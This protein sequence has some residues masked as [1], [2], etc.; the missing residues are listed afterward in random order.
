MYIMQGGLYRIQGHRE[1][2]MFL[3]GFSATYKGKNVHELVFVDSASLT[4]GSD[5]ALLRVQPDNLVAATS[6]PGSAVAT[7]DHLE[8]FTRL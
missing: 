4:G 5:P 3:G 8:T 6:A 7:S 2:T 1:A